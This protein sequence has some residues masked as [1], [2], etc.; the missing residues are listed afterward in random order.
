VVVDL[1]TGDGRAVLARAATEL[2]SLVIGIDA[3]AAAMAEMSRRAS[4]S[5]DASSRANAW[6]LVEAAEALPGPLADAASLVTI[7]MP[8]GSL[9]RG[10]IGQ[11]APVLRGI[12]S[13]VAPGGRVEILVSVV[14]SDNVEGLVLLDMDAGAQIASAWAALGLELVSM[15]PASNGDLVA[16]RSAWARRLGDRSV[17]RLELVRP[18][19]AQPTRPLARWATLAP[20]STDPSVPTPGRPPAEDL[21]TWPR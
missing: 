19:A 18:P 20:D 14:P 2:R 11:D 7:T 5:R 10:V 15:R 4:R 3:N 6:F 9:L 17:W 1:G 13:I 8:W 16:A 21:R 12:A